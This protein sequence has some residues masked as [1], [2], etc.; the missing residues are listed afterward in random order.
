MAKRFITPFAEAG[1]RSEIPDTPTGTDVNFQ[2]GYPA[3]YELDPVT[4]PN[5]KYVER[6][7]TNQ[8]F[9]D[10]TS[11]IKDWQERAYPDFITASDNGSVAFPY[12]KFAKVYHDGV[13]YE[14]LV[15][16]N[17][18]VP[19]SSDWFVFSRKLGVNAYTVSEL[20]SY[21]FEVGRFIY[22]LD[23]DYAKFKVVTGQ[24]ANGY[25]ILDAANSKQVQLII[26]KGEFNVCAFGAVGDG[27][28]DDYLP[29]QR[30]N[31][32]AVEY[33]NN[34]GNGAIILYPPKD[35]YI[36]STVC[37][38]PESEN[39]LD[40]YNAGQAGTLTTKVENITILGYGA[41]LFCDTATF[42]PLF[43]FC[44][45]TSIEADNV[46]VYGL[47][48]ESD[49]NNKTPNWFDSSNY[50]NRSV[51]TVTGEAGFI[52]IRTTGFKFIDCPVHHCEIGLVIADD[53]TF[54]IPTPDP[55]NTY[56]SEVSGCDFY[57][58]WQLMSMTYGATEELII[59]S[60]NFR[61]GFIK[62]VQESDQ[63]R[64]MMIT[65]NTF[66]DISGILT[67]TN[68]TQIVNNTFNNLLGGF[69]LQPQGGSNPSTDYNY[70][71]TNMLI[72]D[73]TCYSD[74][75]TEVDGETVGS[76]T[77]LP[78][79]FIN[80]SATSGATAGQIVNID[81]LRIEGNSAVLWG[82]GG[83]SSGS[84]INR[85]GDAMVNIKS[86][87][88]T[89]KNKFVLKSGGTASICIAPNSV[90]SN[91]TI[92]GTLD[93]SRNEFSREN[94]V[95]LFEFQMWFA[96]SSEKAVVKF[97]DNIVDMAGS[98]NR[99]V[100][101]GGVRN[102]KS[103]GNQYNLDDTAIATSAV[104]WMAGV[105]NYDIQYNDIQR[106]PALGNIGYIVYHDGL[107]S[108]TY[109]AVNDKPKIVVKNNT[110]N[111]AQFV[112]NSNVSFPASSLGFFDLFGNTISTNTT[113]GFQTYPS[114]AGFNA[115]NV[116]NPHIETDPLP[117]SIP[118]VPA[119]FVVWN[120]S[121]T[122]GTPTGW[123]YN[124]V[125]WRTISTNP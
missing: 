57:N 114:I 58:C 61:Y 33:A 85:D 50:F 121:F 30:A 6:D 82:V 47:K 56:R 44:M 3:E 37:P 26:E 67:N 42:N 55:M 13:L 102:F 35:F 14:S 115:Y 77:A 118:L 64:A 62:L 66:R 95:S 43:P 117:A 2:T 21:D 78:Q 8:L 73:N 18:S 49:L 123:R 27:V 23:R 24:T 83:N 90:Y 86:M 74:H 110:I 96:S 41:R 81:N 9:N 100:T 119:Y 60:N 15:D 16:S 46:K 80:I 40:R 103:K 20:L 112:F 92:S 48:F 28:N 75:G 45:M 10:I 72:K 108:G 69:S 65:T 101:V 7:K 52:A 84:F 51:P 116:V 4:D 88:V 70:D 59:H 104:Y 106:D 107:V 63:G 12:Q 79:R 11:N 105:K 98:S 19:P 97:N 120:G 99:V 91:T 53:R 122:A 113:S 93:I 54:T 76:G 1:D 36:T 39:T 32:A 38:L 87:S 22:I 29:I 89:D 124:G 111:V 17:T 34:V 109:S 25:D 94:T 31:V 5:A 68:D 125:N 71:L